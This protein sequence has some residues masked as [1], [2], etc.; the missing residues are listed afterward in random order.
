VR[1]TEAADRS[2]RAGGAEV[3]LADATHHPALA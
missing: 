3:Q 2:L 1:V